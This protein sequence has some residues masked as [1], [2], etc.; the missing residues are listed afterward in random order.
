MFRRGGNSVCFLF[1]SSLF[2]PLY[3]PCIITAFS[4]AHSQ[5]FVCYLIAK[6]GAGEGRWGQGGTRVDASFDS[7]ALSSPGSLQAPPNA[8]LHS[9]D[10]HPTRPAVALPPLGTDVKWL[11]SAEPGPQISILKGLIAEMSRTSAQSERRG[12]SF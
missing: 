12:F 10:P 9:R 1:L 8:R 5:P 11:R 7:S 2:S 3:L 4:S 6:S